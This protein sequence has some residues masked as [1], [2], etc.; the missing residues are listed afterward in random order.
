MKPNSGTQATLREVSDQP[1]LS[2]AVSRYFAGN[3]SVRQLRRSQQI[4]E[5]S[6]QVAKEFICVT[7]PVP[8][9]AWRRYSRAPA[10][11][12]CWSFMEYFC[13]EQIARQLPE[14][15]RSGSTDSCRRRGYDLVLPD[16]NN[17]LVA[18]EVKYSS[19]PKIGRSFWNALPNL[20]CKRGFVVYPGAD[21]YPLAE[22]VQ[23]LPARSLV[24]LCV[25][26]PSP[27]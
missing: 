25:L 22:N 8:H 1:A 5:A 10:G 14:V 12:R 3:V 9:P 6:G 23:A 18:V 2:K 13:V 27:Q 19:A 7:P 16:I 4:S 17:K 26:F 20:S 11:S 21:T 15:S 24:N